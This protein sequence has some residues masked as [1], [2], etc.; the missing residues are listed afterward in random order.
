MKSLKV[1]L[2]FKLSYIYGRA[3]ENL[4]PLRSDSAFHHV[5]A[6]AAVAETFVTDDKELRT[7]LSRVPM[8]G[9][10]VT[11]LPGFLGRVRWRARRLLTKGFDYSVS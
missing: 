10:E 2:G 1:L 8:E 4:A 11:D 6:A 9:L 5:V 7:L 3:F